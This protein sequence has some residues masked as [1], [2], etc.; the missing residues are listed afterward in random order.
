METNNKEYYLES[1]E[2][3]DNPSI[4]VLCLK[5][6]YSNGIKKVGKKFNYRELIPT[7]IYENQ[8]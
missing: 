2:K 8:L 5:A 3:V 1:V 6:I 4:N 7:M